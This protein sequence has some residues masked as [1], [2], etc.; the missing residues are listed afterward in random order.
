ML[1]GKEI[2]DLDIIKGALEK[3]VQQQGIDVRVKEIAKVDTHFPGYIPVEGKTQRP[4]SIHCAML[5]DHWTLQPGYYE[6]TFIEGCE[7]PDNLGLDFK[8][9]S[10]LIRCGSEVMS[11]H[12][13]PG[14]KT[15]NMGCYMEVRL[16]ISIEK[17][18]CIAQAMVT[19]SNKV[20]NTYNGQWQGD[21]QRKEKK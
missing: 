1:T 20:E 8:S 16:P 10:S 19:E 9:R 4:N 5:E 18:A 7:M 11:G 6:I 17:G 2:F 14:F 21:N 13:D 3:N 12:F 15:D